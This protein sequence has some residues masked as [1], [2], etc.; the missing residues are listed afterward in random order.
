MWWERSF[1]HNT[2]KGPTQILKARR[3]LSGKSSVWRLSKAKVEFEFAKF[4]RKL[5]EPWRFVVDSPRGK[6]W[7][8]RGA[9]QCANEAVSL[10]GRRGPGAR[11]TPP[12]L[13]SKFV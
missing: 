7:G 9:R 5:L 8:G 1:E 12:A 4:D 11:A 10:A 13:I 6:T 3:A 2:P